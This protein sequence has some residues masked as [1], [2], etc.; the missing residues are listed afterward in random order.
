MKNDSRNIFDIAVVT[1][2][3]VAKFASRILIC[4]A[5]MAKDLARQGRF[6]QIVTVGY[7]SG[8]TVTFSSMEENTLSVCFTD[9]IKPIFGKVIMAG[10]VV[11]KEYD[12][13]MS[14]MFVSAVLRCI[15]VV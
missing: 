11:L 10:E 4:P 14:D 3:I 6:G 8:D 7:S 15:G 5:E 9:D 12:E 13:P 2:N 1:K